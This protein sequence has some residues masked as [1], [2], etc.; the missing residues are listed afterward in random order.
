M[1]NLSHSGSLSFAYCDFGHVR[2]LE[3][4]LLL[5]KKVAG[6]QDGEV[7]TQRQAE[8]RESQKQSNSLEQNVMQLSVC[9]DFSSE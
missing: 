6:A 7:V 2:G 3:F 8:C 1:L 5:P 4:I 9:W